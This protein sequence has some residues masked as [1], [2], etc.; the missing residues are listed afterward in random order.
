MLG[1]ICATLHGCSAAVEPLPTVYR[2]APGN[3]YPDP[4]GTPGRPSPRRGARRPAPTTLATPQAHADDPNPTP[5]RLDR[6]AVD[7][8]AQRTA[9]LVHPAGTAERPALRSSSKTSTRQAPAD[10]CVGGGDVAQAAE[11][12]GGGGDLRVL[13]V[14]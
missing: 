7:S 4:A 1:G 5:H 10:L 14:G 2:A 9:D 6:S 13:V 11:D 8:R 3:P 12:V